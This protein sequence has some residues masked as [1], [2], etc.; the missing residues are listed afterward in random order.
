[1]GIIAEVLDSRDILRNL[2]LRELRSS[3]KGSALGFM[4]SLLNPL[5]TMAI[6]TVVFSVVLQV[7]LPPNAQ[8]VRNFPAFL[9]VG[10]LP[11]NLVSLSMSA[12]ATSLV[13]NGNLIRK[14]YFFR[15]TLPAS[16]VLANAVNFLV[17]LGL[18]LVVLLLV[19]VNFWGSIWLLPVPLLALLLLS[20]GLALLTSVANLY[21]RDT[22]YLVGLFTMAW[23]YATPIIYPLSFVERVGEPWLTLYRLNPATALIETFRAILYDGRLPAAL[24]LL[25]SLGSAT[26]V[27]AVGWLVFQRAEP[28]FAEEV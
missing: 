22:Q 11:W 20:L 8:G 25:W 19:G 15:A 9:L 10:L 4:W 17:G 28:H 24:D 7:Q 12:G 2:L 6:F 5:V 18:L 13:A 1:M 3:Y 27:L 23:F 16:V 26:I 14:V 21:Y